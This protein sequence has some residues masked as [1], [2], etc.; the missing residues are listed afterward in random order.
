[1]VLAT[2]VAGGY[3]AASELP[4]TGREHVSADPHV[5]CGT[6][7]PSCNGGFLPFGQSRSLDIHLTHRAFMYLASVLVLALFALVLAQRR[8]LDPESGRR[9]TLW[10]AL[11]VAILWRRSCSAR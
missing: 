10:A 7:F 1:M 6:D 11:A 2:I 8:R 3:M 5:A 4:G 9:L